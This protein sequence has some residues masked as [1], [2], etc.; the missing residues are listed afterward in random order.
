MQEPVVQS[1]TSSTPDTSTKGIPISSI[2]DLIENKNLNMADTARVLGC[3]ERNVAR[4]L[5]TAGLT[6]GYL[7]GYKKNRADIFAAYQMMI[8]NSI[9]PVDLQ[10][11]S[12]SQKML[13]FGITYDKERLERG[14]S[15]ENIA[16]ADIIKAEQVAQQAVDRYVQRFGPDA[17]PAAA[18]TTTCSVNEGDNQANEVT[19]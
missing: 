7:G 1:P 9:R 19:S 17:I 18:T 12:L 3:D 6:P 14:Q 8:L 13:G 10:K 4:R 11:A 5:E 15:T 2:I 16:Y